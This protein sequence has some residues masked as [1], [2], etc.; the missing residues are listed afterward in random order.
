[1]KSPTPSARR[2]PEGQRSAFRRRRLAASPS[3][4]RWLAR[5]LTP[6][7]ALLGIAT[8]FAAAAASVLETTQAR[9]VVEHLT[10]QG[11]I[12]V[13][14]ALAAFG[15]GL[16]VGSVVGRSLPAFIV[17]MV[18]CV[19]LAF[20]AEPVRLGWLDA[21]KVPI[22]HVISNGYSFGFAWRAPDG[23][24]T[25]YNQDAFAR[26]VPAGAVVGSPNGEQDAFEAWLYDHGDQLL[27]LGVPD[28]VARGWLPIEFTG[29]SLIG[30]GA[31]GAAAIVVNRRRPT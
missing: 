24:L 3:R 22:D 11:P 13:A 10:L 2:T 29:M 21:R 7:L 25:P 30:L 5:Q 14:R 4:T 31:I 9:T 20:V 19:A 23:T 12:V 1:M 17:G 26:L 27:Q 16:L 18:L 28:E 6:V 15:I 8:V